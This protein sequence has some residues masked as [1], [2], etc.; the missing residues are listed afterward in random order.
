M[1]TMKNKNS[2][3]VGTSLKDYEI[4]RL[5][6]KGF[7]GKVYKVKWKTNDKIYALKWIDKAKVKN[8]DQFLNLTAEREVMISIN[9]PFIVKMHWAFQT[10]SKLWFVMDNWGGG[11]LFYY[12]RDQ[13]KFTE[14]VT[15]FYAAQIVSSSWTSS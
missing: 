3:N 4:I 12:L 14:E 11:E 10:K 6:G 13:G 2:G 1:S 8:K 9:H 7:F 5:I 15:W